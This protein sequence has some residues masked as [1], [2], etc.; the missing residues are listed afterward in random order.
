MVAD[1]CVRDLQGAIALIQV[2]F[3]VKFRVPI[4]LFYTD[5]PSLP[6]TPCNQ[7]GIEK[8]LR[9]TECTEATMSILNE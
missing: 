6:D 5:S 8:D 4:G 1:D 7:V 3:P 2:R 9:L